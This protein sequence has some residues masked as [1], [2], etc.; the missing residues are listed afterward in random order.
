MALTVAGEMFYWGR[1][2]IGGVTERE[3]EIPS[4]SKS[5]DKY[6]IIPQEVV[7]EVNEYKQRIIQIC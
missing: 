4:Q 2:L 5:M 6:N 3:E 7:I 1:S